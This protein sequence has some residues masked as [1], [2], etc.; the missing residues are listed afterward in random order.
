M[1]HVIAEA[2]AAGLPVIATRDNGTEQQITDNE[3]GLFVPHGSPPAVAA[4]LGRLLREPGLGRRLGRNLRHKVERE[5]SAR[6]VIRRWEA[7]FDEVIAE[8]AWPPPAAASHGHPRYHASRESL[9]HRRPQEAVEAPGDPSV[10]RAPSP[11]RS[12]WPADSGIA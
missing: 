7:L 10:C 1:P 12:V 6:V 11:P 5:Y 9:P 8:G 2:G 3:T 4:T